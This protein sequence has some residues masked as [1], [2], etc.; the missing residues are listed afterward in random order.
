MSKSCLNGG[1]QAID[2]PG[3]FTLQ[4]K[5][6][7]HVV[8]NSGIVGVDGYGPLGPFQ[9]AAAV[10]QPAEADRTH[11]IG[12][13]II[14]VKLNPFFHGPQGQAV[15]GQGRF[16]VIQSGVCL[17]GKIT[18]LVV[19]AAAAGSFKQLGGQVQLA[20]LE[21]GSTVQVGCFILLGIQAHGLLELFPGFFEPVHEPQGQ[22]TGGMSLGQVRVE[23]QRPEAGPVS[24]FQLDVPG[25]S[26]EVKEHGR[27]LGNAGI[28]QGIVGVDFGRLGEHLPGKLITLTASLVVEL[29][30][31][32]IEIVGVGVG[33]RS[34]GQGPK[35]VI[36]QDELQGPDH[37]LRDLILDGKDILEVP[38]VSFRPEMVA[39]GYVDELDK[40]P[41]PVSGPLNAAFEQGI[42]MQLATYFAGILVAGLEDQ[43]GSS[44][45]HPQSP[46]L[47]QGVYYFLGHTVAKV[48]L[49]S[50]SAQV[51]QRQNGYRPLVIFLAPAVLDPP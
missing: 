7:G 33:S 14:R 35:L 17:G 43:G 11:G 44:G 48:F 4:G 47:G 28:G 3:L 27:A 5:Q 50:L 42:D 37:V 34:S 30:S 25:L 12:P 32:Q 31:A 36:A 51:G 39:R 41:Q 46:D 16:I 10:S 40:N 9:P 49:L 26:I 15:S 38:V 1:F 13:G 22:A 6:T 29:A 21:T 23:L 18:G 20:P 19:L 8:L 24:F 2:G 45:R